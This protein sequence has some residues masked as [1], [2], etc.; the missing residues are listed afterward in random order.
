MFHVSP[1]PARCP[2]RARRLRALYPSIS[3]VGYL[4]AGPGDQYPEDA[5]LD[6]A[7]AADAGAADAGPAEAGVVEPPGALVAPPPPCVQPAMRA[8]ANATVAR[9]FQMFFMARNTITQAA[10]V[11]AMMVDVDPTDD[12]ELIDAGDQRRLERFGERV[13]DRPAPAAVRPAAASRR[14]WAAADLRFD[15]KGGWSGGPQTPWTFSSGGVVLELRAGANGQL[16]IYPEHRTLWPWLRKRLEDREAPAVLHLFAATGATTLALAVAG[17]EVTHVDGS[18]AAVAWARRNAELSGLIDRPIR[19]IVD[20]AVG[21]TLREAR[22]GRQYD[23]IVLDPPSYGHGPRGERWAID[24]A[25]P[26]LLTAVAS[27]AATDAFILVTAHSTGVDEDGLQTT[28]SA[29]F[30]RASVR[31]ERIELTATSGAVLPLGV[32]ARIIRR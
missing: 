9:V 24:R 22:R 10:A 2:I 30:P 17:A 27:V 18:K 6:A 21:Y 8:A 1:A 23:G 19:W 16:G 32:A 29:A 4:R 28:V 15:P 11:L 20:D 3:G 13:V 25:L 7:G 5:A 14:E 26:D 12:Y 31:V